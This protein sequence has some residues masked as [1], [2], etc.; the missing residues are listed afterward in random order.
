MSS[1]DTN[2]SWGTDYAKPRCKTPTRMYNS[3]AEK[4]EKMREIL[5]K[6]ESGS[7]GQKPRS[8]SRSKERPSS[9][10]KMRPSSDSNNQEN[11]I[12]S[13]T[14]GKQPRVYLSN[15]MCFSKQL[16]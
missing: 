13:N 8:E 4:S 14:K 1:S 3:D 16:I 6:A 10:G 9:R 5:K 12:P 2:S 11:A 7:S 15:V